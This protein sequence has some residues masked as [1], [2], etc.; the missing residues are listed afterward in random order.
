MKPKYEAPGTE[1]LKLTE[2]E[3]ISNFAFNFNLRCY[4]M[5]ASGAMTVRFDHDDLQVHIAGFANATACDD[6]VGRSRFTLC[7]PS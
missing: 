7:I 6:K 1:R 3:L 2:D 4:I 5:E